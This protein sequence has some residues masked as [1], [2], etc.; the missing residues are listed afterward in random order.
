MH[1][2]AGE[3]GRKSTRDLESEGGTRRDAA[4]LRELRNRNCQRT[5]EL[6]GELSTPS[7]HSDT[8]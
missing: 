7:T 4:D 3:V 6:R 8:R 1:E 5:E 2:L